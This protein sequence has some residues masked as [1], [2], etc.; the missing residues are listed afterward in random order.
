MKKTSVIALGLF[1]ATL[2][3]LSAQETAAPATPPAQTQS[4]EKPEAASPKELSIV[5]NGQTLDNDPPPVTVDGRVLI[6]LRK[7]FNALGAEVEYKDKII[8]ARRGELTVVLSP[9]EKAAKIAGQ[10][11][12]LDVPPM[13]LD[14]VTYVPL[15]FVAQALGDEVAYDGPNKTIK[16]TP[17]VGISV[18]RVTEI[19]GMLKRLAV[20]HQ[21]A[22]LKLW[23]PSITE[24]VYY[25]GLDDRA[26]APY[27]P[28]D[29]AALLSGIG[30]KQDLGELVLD[31]MDG[32]SK[33]QKKEAVAFLGL[34]HSIPNKSAYGVSPKVEREVQEF[35][36]Q[37]LKEDKDV[38]QRRQAALSLAV[39]APLDHVIVESILD[40]YANSSNLWET[41]PVQQFFQFQADKIRA[42]PNLAMVRS[43]V[44]DVNSLY[45]Q[46]ILR[47][48]DGDPD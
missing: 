15:R 28:E 40:F 47:Y 6:P 12:E 31:V 5:I 8:S 43:R 32:Y 23:D 4:A 42:M 45:T 38:I 2:Q 3:P 46:A 16:V 44:A 34:V 21:G 14:G 48:L 33:L 26:T 13:L 9:N 10:D 41:F 35:L 22:I 18:D 36:L 24:V 39:G 37:V 27:S 19:K 29:H 7:V 25:R 11:V 30:V 1:C 17:A 20:G